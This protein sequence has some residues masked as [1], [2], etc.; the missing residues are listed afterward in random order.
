MTRNRAIWVG[1]AAGV[2]TRFPVLALTE[3]VRGLVRTYSA[4]LG[5][6]PPAGADVLHIALAVADEPND[7]RR[8]NRC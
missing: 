4:R 6:A 5:L 2:V 7:E 1:T 8:S 3:E